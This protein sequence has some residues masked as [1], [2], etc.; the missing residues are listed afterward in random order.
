MTRERDVVEFDLAQQEERCDLQGEASHVR[1]LLKLLGR[2][3]F[4]FKA[5]HD[6]KVF[7]GHAK[8]GDGTGFHCKSNVIKFF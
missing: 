6:S 7:S 1:S 2:S 4:L 8:Y 5:F 3:A